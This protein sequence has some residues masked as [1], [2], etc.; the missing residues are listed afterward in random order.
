M[1]GGVGPFR[2]ILYAQPYLN[3][4]SILAYNSLHTNTLRDAT[5]ISAPIRRRHAPT[6]MTVL[7]LQS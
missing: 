3:V 2:A 5:A 6:P 7:I 1:K 4:G